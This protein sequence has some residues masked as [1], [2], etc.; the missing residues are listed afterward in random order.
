VHARDGFDRLQF[1]HQLVL[2]DDVV[3]F[4][5]DFQFHA[6]PDDRHRILGADSQ[7]AFLK[8]INEDR[9]VCG[10]QQPW[11]ELLVDLVGCVDDDFRQ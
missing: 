10:F 3:S 5:P 9:M 7:A 8:F 2:D 6:V 4:E 11:T 1:Q